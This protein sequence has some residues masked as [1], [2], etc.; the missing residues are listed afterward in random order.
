MKKSEVIVRKLQISQNKAVNTTTDSLS[1]RSIMVSLGLY[2]EEI[3]LLSNPEVVEEWNCQTR[4][5]AIYKD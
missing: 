4:T 2:R 1:L 5:P 3:A